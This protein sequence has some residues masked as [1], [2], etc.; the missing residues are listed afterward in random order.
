MLKLKVW[1]YN[2]ALAKTI[3]RRFFMFSS[4]LAFIVIAMLF[5]S[6]IIE[7]ITKKIVLFKEKGMADKYEMSSIHRYALVDGI[8]L[9]VVSLGALAY[10]LAVLHIIALPVME[11][12]STTTL[13]LGVYL[14]IAL[15]IRFTMLKRK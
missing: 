4:I 3:Q 10:E 14:I 5:V 6:G 1:A 15:I 7:I 11:E 13:A 2:F 8:A 12:L 9:V